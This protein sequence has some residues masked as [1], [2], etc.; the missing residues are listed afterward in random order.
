MRYTVRLNS[1]NRKTL[2]RL[3]N[4]LYGR[5][6]RK[7]EALQ[8]NPRP[9]GVEKLA[10]RKDLYRVRVGDWRIVYAIHDRELVLVVIRTG[11]RRDVYRRR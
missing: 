8:E 2:D 1:R 5:V 9:T 3:P 10:G 7:L 4:D 6:L 11:H